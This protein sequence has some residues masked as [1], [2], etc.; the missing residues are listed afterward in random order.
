M[1]YKI[2][3]LKLK[4]CDKIRYIGLTKNSIEQRLKQHIS[5]SKHHCNINANWLKKHIGN[6]EIVLIEDMIEDLDKAYLKEIEYIKFFKSIGANLNN[7]TDGGVA[8]GQFNLGKVRSLE[9]RKKI[10]I[11][12]LGKKL[13]ER[14]SEWCEKISDGLKRNHSENTRI[15]KE[16]HKEKIGQSNIGKKSKIIYKIDTSNNIVEVYK[17]IEEASIKNEVHYSTI[18]KWCK[19]D[20]YRDDNYK[21]VYKEKYQNNTDITYSSYKHYNSKSILL[22]DTNNVLIKEYIT[23][24]EASKESGISSSSLVRYCQGKRKPKNGYIWKYK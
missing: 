21:F 12:K 24:S 11:S 4:D 7:M 16:G 10:S 13:P 8:T 14:N 20:F 2:Y 17:G 5:L 18:R 3:G 9:T 19:E 6:V 22:F 23:I 15:L 1:N